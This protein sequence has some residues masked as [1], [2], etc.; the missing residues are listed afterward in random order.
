MNIDF[1]KIFFALAIIVVQCILDNYVDL[2]IYLRIV[3]VPYLILI[4]P[5]RYR[6]IS[7]MIMAFLIG[8]TVDIFTTGVLGTNAG[9]LTAVA[10]IRQKMLYAIMDERNMERH[11]SPDFKVMGVGKGIFY[12]GVPYLL[13][14]IVYTLLDN[15]GMRPFAITIPKILA[16]TIVS[17]VISMLLFKNYKKI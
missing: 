10:F 7:A 17:G 15:F 8:L 9:A 4:L 2:G 11:D 3:L 13:F 5:Y 16:G 12:I 6:T 14:F 1:K